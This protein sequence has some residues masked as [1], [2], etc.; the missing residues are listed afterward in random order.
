MHRYR[1]FGLVSDWDESLRRAFRDG[2]KRAGLSHAQFVAALSWY[3]DHAG[4]AS[5]EAQLAKAF[6]EFATLKT[7]APEH[8]DVAIG[9]YEAIRDGGPEAVA[10]GQP[11]PEEDRATV[12]RVEDLMRRNPAQYWRDAELQDAIF[13]ARERLA[14][15][16]DAP[17]PIPRGS[18]SDRQRIKD[19]EALLRDPSGAGQRRYW[20]DAAMRAEYAQALS[21]I[22]GEAA[23]AHEAPGVPAPTAPDPSGNSVPDA[24]PG[25]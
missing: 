5:D 6:A 8:R 21:Q 14:A 18:E 4:A 19:V 22:H 1:E 11:T 24:A 15:V 17:A 7:W 9:L 10:V 2:F 25:A 13:E 12:A 20:N 16:P 3:R 23:T